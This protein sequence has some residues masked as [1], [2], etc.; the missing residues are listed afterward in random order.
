MHNASQQVKLFQGE[1]AL[2]ATATQIANLDLNGNVREDSLW[3][4]MLTV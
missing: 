2:A 1:F 3:H 4:G